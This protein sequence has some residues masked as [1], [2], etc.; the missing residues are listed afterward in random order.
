M[1]KL[2][3]SLLLLA[4]VATVAPAESPAPAAA[5][6]ALAAL[7]RG[8]IHSGIAALP[9]P[10]H[11]YELY[12]PTA[13]D[14]GRR[15]PLLL[16]F[17]P[18]AR[19]RLA[20]E[21]FVPSAERWGWIVA[22]SNDTRSD[23]PFDA[24]LRAVNAMFPD[25]LARLPIDGGRVYAT[26]FS[27]GAIVAWV[28][29]LRAGP[30]AGVISVGG[31]PPDGLERELPS[32]ALWATAGTT[33]FNHDSTRAL[34]ALAAAAHQPHRLEFFDGGHTW[35]AAEDAARAV[36]WME[37]LAMRQGRRATDARAVEELLRDDLAGA[38]A[39]LASGDRLAAMRRFAAVADTFRG[40]A[41]VTA[42][43][44]RAAELAGDPAVRA[45][46]DEEAW[47]IAFARSA[48]LRMARAA[49]ALRDDS[50]VTPPARLEGM[51]GLRELRR[52]AAEP[53][54][55]GETGRRT[56]EDALTFFGL[57][58]ASEYSAAE[59]W[60][61]AVAVLSLATAIDPADPGA[62][63]G[64]A[65][66]QARLGDEKGALASLERALDCGLPRPSRI[67]TEADLTSLRDRPGFARL[68]ERVRAAAP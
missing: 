59:D 13:F 44:R 66:A 31:R 16:V 19:G 9:D 47:G 39:L 22:S 21:I 14:P 61:R 41:D 23:G 26:G 38:E 37:L 58:L 11:T 32:F 40:L 43:E 12:L 35:F 17:D 1:Q 51:L 33:D 60:P 42:A 6:I 20:A 67:E 65:R 62:W 48:R 49:A 34:D 55:R 36:A 57:R 64:L 63:Y 3:N 7:E 30:L 52:V 56:L 28:L 5:P 15:W 45:A 54:A 29:G 4:A 50:G 2:R 53:G 8:V 25:L 46:L 10:A 24:N 27:G 18:A 68:V